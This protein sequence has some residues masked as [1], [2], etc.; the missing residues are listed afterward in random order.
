MNHFYARRMVLSFLLFIPLVVFA[1]Q[2]SHKIVINE[3]NYL[4]Y[5]PDGYDADSTQWPMMVFLHGV[6]ECG[7]DVD[8]IKV[9]GPPKL[10]EQGKK[11]PFIVV[12]PQ[13]PERGWRPDFIRKLILNLSENYRVD[14]DRIYLTGLSMGGFGTW[15]TA[16]SYPEM[17]AAILP[18]CGGGSPDRVYGLQHMPVWCFHGDSDDVVNISNSQKMIDALK[19]LNNPNVKFTVYPGVKHD[20]WT[21]TYSN[22]EIYDWM[23][24]HKRFKYTE[25]QIDKA[26]LEIYAGTYAAQEYPDTIQL[27]AGDN[28]LDLMRKGKLQ[29]T[30][31]PFSDNTFFMKPDA[32]DY[33]EVNRDAEGKVVSM[34]FVGSMYKSVY[35]RVD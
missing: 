21:Q 12:S 20:S 13:A 1:Q 7:D 22:D 4:L 29:E 31:H 23:L 10:I 17:F 19:P 32:F 11:F 30:M 24:S 33:M 2:T 14:S 25:V 6:G 16:Q 34:T 28:T 15:Q 35:N 27:V 26:L 8:K 3:M 9:H 18:I 5:L